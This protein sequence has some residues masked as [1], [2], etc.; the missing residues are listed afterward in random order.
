MQASSLS[1]CTLS[2]LNTT[3]TPLLCTTVRVCVCA[4]G[5]YGG[6]GLR[7]ELAPRD[8]RFAVYRPIRS[9]LLAQGNSKDS[10]STRRRSSLR[11]RSSGGASSSSAGG[12]AA[13]SGEVNLR[14]SQVTQA[15]VA[16]ASAAAAAARLAAK[17]LKR[18]IG[19]GIARRDSNPTTRS[20][21]QAR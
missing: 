2:T 15:P 5:R 17:K 10:V 20:S 16:A 13:D 11:R 8:E 21:S 6:C 4:A 3:L 1:V 19:V 9:D 18:S 14:F 7:F 12:A